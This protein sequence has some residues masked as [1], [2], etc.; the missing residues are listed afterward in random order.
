MGYA[1]VALGMVYRT[2]AEAE[3]HFAADYKKLTGEPLEV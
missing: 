3:K 2:Q 1:L